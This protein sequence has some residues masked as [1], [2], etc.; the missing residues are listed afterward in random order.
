MMW[1]VASVALA[2][3]EKRAD[4]GDG[5]EEVERGRPLDHVFK[6]GCA[7]SP[8]RKSVYKS[9]GAKDTD[10]DPALACGRRGKRPTG[11]ADTGCPV[12]FGCPREA[13][14]ERERQ[15]PAT[16]PAHGQ[17]RVPEGGGSSEGSSP[18]RERHAATCGRIA[19]TLL[20]RG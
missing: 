13:A 14:P 15:M 11:R 6:H 4:V 16:I 2:Y 3:G 17:A 20:S 12:D 5:E 19:M 18:S 1:R 9:E 10:N 8:L 7:R